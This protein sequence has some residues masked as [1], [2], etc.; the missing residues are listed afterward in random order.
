MYQARIQLDLVIQSEQASVLIITWSKFNLRQASVAHV[1]YFWC[2]EGK[3]KA[4]M[5]TESECCFKY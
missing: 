1:Q 4:K 2:F 3:W 5:K